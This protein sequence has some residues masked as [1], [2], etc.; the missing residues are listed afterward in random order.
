[1]LGDG[2]RAKPG[3]YTQKGAKAVNSAG[4]GGVCA[5]LGSRLGGKKTREEKSKNARRLQTANMKHWQYELPQRRMGTVPRGGA[6]NK[7]AKGGKKG[8]RRR[9]SERWVERAE[10]M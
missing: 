10:V 3:E 2:F 8:G 4:K 1:V 9:F 5:T 7:L 6:W